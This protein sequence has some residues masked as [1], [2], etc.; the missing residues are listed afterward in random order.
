MKC[1]RIHPLAA[2]IAA[3]VAVGAAPVQGAAGPAATPLGVYLTCDPGFCEAYAEGGTGGY[4]Y[5]WTNAT[6][7]SDVGA[8]STAY[9]NC[10]TGTGPHTWY[11]YVNVT[12][13]DSSGATF[14]PNVSRA[15]DCQ[16]GD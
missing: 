9:P 10:P 1:M 11:V 5:E 3:G 15:V 4:T 14:T 12:V 2:L 7:L 6:E 16:G 8:Y 13:R